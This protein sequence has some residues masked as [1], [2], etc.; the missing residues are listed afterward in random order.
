MSEKITLV[1]NKTNPI[2][3]NNSVESAFRNQSGSLKK[4]PITRP[5]SRLKITASK[6]SAFISEFPAARSAKSVRI[7]T[8]GNT[9]RKYFTDFPT[10]KVP[11][12]P[13]AIR[14]K[15]WMPMICRFSEFRT[16]PFKSDT[17]DQLKIG[18]SGR[19]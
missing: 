5:I 13:I 3:T 16:F 14:Y 18:I 19:K 9:A 1:P 4:F 2:F 6:L 10:K 15:N 8:I 11:T 17:L 7:Y 12:I